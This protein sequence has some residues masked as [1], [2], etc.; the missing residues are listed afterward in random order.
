MCAAYD[1]MNET[2][3]IIESTWNEVVR[4]NKITDTLI[5]HLQ[6]LLNCSSGNENTL[7]AN[8]DGAKLGKLL[9]EIMVQP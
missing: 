1:V 5:Y 4:K 6:Q 8:A 9:A 2:L 3:Q 7:R